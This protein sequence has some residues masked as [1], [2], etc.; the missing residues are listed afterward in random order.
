[1]KSLTS[2]K[3]RRTNPQPPPPTSSPSPS[4]P[5][6]GNSLPPSSSSPNG[7]HTKSAQGLTLPQVIQLLDVRLINLEKFVNEVKNDPAT[8]LGL[9]IVPSPE[10]LPPVSNDTPQQNNYNQKSV[11]FENDE[12]PNNT[13][14]PDVKQIYEEFDKRY[15]M[16]AE[17]IIHIKN[18]VLNLQSYT[19]DVNK[20][21]ME[22][23]LQLLKEIVSENQPI[24]DEMISWETNPNVPDGDVNVCEEY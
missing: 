15:E 17:E 22:E 13:D 20:L 24:N 12:T 7:N 10:D 21:L 23:R 4:Q 8:V 9:T 6:V 5:R 2:L 3:N 19:M 11:S 14:I 1:M 16:L 18:I